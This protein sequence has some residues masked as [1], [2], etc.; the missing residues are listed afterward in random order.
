[1]TIRRNAFPPEQVLDRDLADLVVPRFPEHQLPQPRNR[2]DAKAVRSEPLKN[3][4]TLGGGGGRHRK[5]HDR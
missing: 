4:T 5:D 1:V 2:A 3:A